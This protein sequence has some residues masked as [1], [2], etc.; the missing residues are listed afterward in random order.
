[1]EPLIIFY[2]GVHNFFFLF[3][4]YMLLFISFLFVIICLNHAFFSYMCLY[5]ICLN[6]TSFLFVIYMFKIFILI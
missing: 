1:M 2:K 3:V 4:I 6:Y 5:F